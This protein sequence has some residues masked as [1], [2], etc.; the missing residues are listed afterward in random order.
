MKLS[1]LSLFMLFASSTLLLIACSKNSSNS[2]QETIL[3][4]SSQ[5]T[6]SENSTRDTVTENSTV[7]T[8]APTEVP[9]EITAKESMVQSQET[10][11]NKV[12][13]TLSPDQLV[14]AST[15]YA[16]AE[17]VTNAILNEGDLARLAA[18]M[19]K[20]RDGEE[21]TVAVIGG[22][23]TQGSSASN[24]NGYANVFSK[25][26][27]DTFPDTKVNFVNAGIGATT[28]Y[29]G[30]H[31]ADKDLLA[32][33]PDVVVVEFSVNDSDSLFYKET[34][35]DLIRRILIA[36]NNPAV[37]QLFM[38]QEDGTSAQAV[39]LHVG[40]WYNLPR[41]SY[42]EAIL[43]EIEKGTFTWDEISPDNIHPNDKGH[44]MVGEILWGYL[45]SVYAKLD[46]ITEEVTPLTK[47]PQFTEGYI[48]ATILDSSNITPVSLGSFEIA[49]VF[50][51][52]PNNWTTN[53]GKEAIVFETEAQ[54]IGIM[55]YKTV[56][57]RSGQYDVY[58]DGVKVWTLNA[59]FTG[60]WGNYADSVE[61]YKSKEK[62]LHKIEIRKSDA[63]TGDVFSIL[64]LLIS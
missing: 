24:N 50:A 20:A 2:T 55:Y 59:D 60:G 61:V 31:R 7:L 1:R 54:N 53:G 26:W 56:D 58:V 46:T 8:A 27:T 14:Q 13:P 4:N 11:T 22:S 10:D 57:G 38:T 45:N 40:F 37:I 34:Y 36:E 52:F 9:E 49:K 64:G 29:L 16:S 19:K 39:H 62:K 21:I 32:Y 42:R 18:V 6:L 25:W 43:K 5:D 63:S 23:I 12:L 3:E 35:E 33:Q 51:P 30:V 48:D 17:M 15:D 41:I 47:E 28:S 44:A